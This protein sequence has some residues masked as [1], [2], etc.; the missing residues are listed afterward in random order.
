MLKQ[1]NIMVEVP[2]ISVKIMMNVESG[3][4]WDL[5]ESQGLSFILSDPAKM[6]KPSI[7]MVCQGPKSTFGVCQLFQT[8]NFGTKSSSFE[9]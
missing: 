9:S 1:G 7:Y 8:W 5:H 3:V 4:D 2:Q 6:A